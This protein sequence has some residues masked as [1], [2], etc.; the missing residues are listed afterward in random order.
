VTAWLWSEQVGIASHE[1]A[2]MLHGLSDLLPVRIHLSLP[3]AWRHRRFRVP[4]GVV[5][6]HADV[7]QEDRQ[8]HGA[9]PVT[10]VRRSLEDCAREGLSPELLRQ[11][12]LQAM[13]RGLVTR[14]ELQEVEEA[15]KPFGGLE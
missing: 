14:P 8:W 11:G 4:G 9:V 12:A 5:L 10:S 6:H 7:R 3:D 15:L 1:T 13:M 2:L